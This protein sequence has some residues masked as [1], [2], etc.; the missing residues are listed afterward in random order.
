MIAWASWELLKEYNKT[1]IELNS[2]PSRPDYNERVEEAR[3]KFKSDLLIAI[4]EYN[5]PTDCPVYSHVFW[6][7]NK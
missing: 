7:K 2:N 5:S 1:I 3:K 4:G 6:E